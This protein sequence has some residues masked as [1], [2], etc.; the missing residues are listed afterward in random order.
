MTLLEA[1]CQPLDAG[2]I[3]NAHVSPLGIHAHSALSLT[4]FCIVVSAPACF[5]SRDTALEIVF[6]L[7]YSADFLTAA[8]TSPYFVYRM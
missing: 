8:V 1:Y 5:T 4:A 2:A 6:V 3:Q 7:P